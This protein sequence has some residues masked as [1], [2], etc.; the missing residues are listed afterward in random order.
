MTVSAAINAATAAW[1]QGD[2]VLGDCWFVHRA[3]PSDGDDTGLIEEQVPGFIV[4]TQTCDIIRGCS[5]RPF[6]DVC[7]LVQVDEHQL[8][9]IR[10]ARTPQYAYIPALAANMLVAD[11]DRTMCVEKSVLASWQRVPGWTSDTEIRAFADCL[12]RKSSRF[13]FPDDFV[14]FCSKFSGRVKDKHGK[15]SDEG[16]ALEAL[17]EIRVAAQPGWDAAEVRLMFWFIKRGDDP[18]FEKE[19][20]PK[21]LDKWVKLMTVS[22]RFI[23]VQGQVTTLADMNADEYVESDVLDLDHLSG[24]G[25]E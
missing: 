3:Q 2:C 13:A 7:P 17:R 1:R 9:Y 21:L 20:W 6:V 22:G 25:A 8:A 16:R 14:S 4:V 10:S 19:D 23:E 5:I 12:R 11:L 24:P 18:V 15:Q